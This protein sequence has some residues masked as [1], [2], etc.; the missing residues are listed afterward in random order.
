MAISIKWHNPEKTILM[1]TFEGTWELADYSRMLDE[2]RAMTNTIKHDFVTVVDMRASATPPS[3]LTSMSEKAADVEGTHLPLQN[4]LIGMG[5]FMEL[6]FNMLNRIY[7]K[8]V[9]NTTAV[10]TYEEALRLAQ[11]HLDEA[12]AKKS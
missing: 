12:A 7:P 10:A 4:I 2:S 3:R 11:K 1:I 5:R 8:S 9:K 6:M